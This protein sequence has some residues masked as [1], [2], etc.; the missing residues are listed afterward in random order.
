MLAE[1]AGGAPWRHFQRL[2]MCS[3]GDVCSS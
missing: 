1:L 2:W 3:L